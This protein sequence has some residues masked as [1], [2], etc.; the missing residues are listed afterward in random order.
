MT[1]VWFCLALLINPTTAPSDLPPTGPALAE[2][3]WPIGVRLPDELAGNRRRRSA[4][5][6]DVL[7]WVPDPLERLRA[8][9]IVPDNT[10]SK[11]FAE[12]PPLRER[13]ARQG[14][15][16]VYLRHFRTGFEHTKSD[17]PPEPD[18]LLKLMP[19]LADATGLPAFE[20][21]PWITF[22]KSS[23]GEFPFR[24]AWLYPKRVIAGVT[25]HGETPTWPIPDW[26]GGQEESVLY[27]AL[28]GQTE[29]EGTWYRHVRPCLLNYRATTRWLPHQ[30]VLR[31]IGHGNYPDGHG[32]PG[33]DKPVAPDQISVK[34]AWDYLALFIDKAIDLR[35]PPDADPA[36]GP[37]TLRQVD[38]DQGVLVHK[39]A[40]EVR[41][42]M[43]WMAL[44]TRGERYNIVAWPEFRED[45]FDPDPQPLADADLIRPAGQVDPAQR[46]DWFWLPDEETARAWLALHTPPPG[47]PAPKGP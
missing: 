12:H 42:Q 14:V 11:H 15:A 39:R 9:L 31:G 16:I 30:V 29:W 24:A 7:V 20:H 22:G 34:R 37:V 4:H 17:P 28:N 47:E 18:N 40:I 38:P 43:R 21:A 27:V 1:I 3:H 6:A 13:L 32:T 33:W 44:W 5:R 35:L 25:Y 36:Q 8:V 10:D 23:R 41:L 26:A 2:P 19:H 45:Q 46:G